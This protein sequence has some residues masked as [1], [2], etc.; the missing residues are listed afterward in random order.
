MKTLVQKYPQSLGLIAVFSA[1]FTSF[2]A[3]NTVNNAMPRIAAEL[4]GM[5]YY[6][7][8]IA[9]PALVSAFATLIFGKLSDMYGR[10]IILL[11]SM[12]FMLTG[13][14]LSAVSQTF[15]LL[16]GALSI[17]GLGMGAI[18]PLCFSVLG[19]MFA[20]A[21]RSQWAGLLN[22]S[23]GITAFVGPTL[24]GWFVDNLSWRYIFWLDIPL[25]LLSGGIVLFGLPK[26]A[27]GRTHQIDFLGSVYLAVASTTLIL[28]LSWAGS[29]YPWMSFQILGLLSVSLLFWVLFLRTESRA[30]E[31]MLDPKVLTNRTFL[32]ASGAALL[33]I[34]GFTAVLVYYPLFLQGVQ[35]A[36]AT[37]SG[38]IITPFSVLTSFMGIPAGL[39]ISKTK[40][41]KWMYVTGY[42]ILVLVMWGAVSL[43]ATTTIA[44]GF[45]LSAMAGI[46]LGTIP[47]INAL[48]VQYAVPKRLLGVATGG[49][50]FFVTL[51]KAIAPALLGSFLNAT[52]ARELTARLPSA[53]GQSLDQA[54]RASIS[55]PRV[56]LSTSAF[57]ELKNNFSRIGDQGPAFFENVV[58]AIRSSLEAGLKGVFIIGAVTMLVSFLLILTIPELELES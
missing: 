33:S 56:L 46:G 52:Y 48:V 4:N 17:L 30:A 39:L 13:V 18:Q 16:V 14:V 26:H 21:E 10:R 23:S 28:G 41:Y 55:N 2:F 35:N 44:W 40:R 3:M 34:F 50:Y 5:Q 49:L 51:G 15:V 32:T 43:T 9:I 7:W 58:Q 37:L 22:I 47:T 31:P 1:Y 24:G 45:V 36:S 27:R 38:K 19:D 20:P 57:A 29:T 11:V 6:S 25:I 12:G 8:A 53:L 54:T 42:A